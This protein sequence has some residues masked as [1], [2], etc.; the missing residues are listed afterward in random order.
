MSGLTLKDPARNDPVPHL[1]PSGPPAPHMSYQPAPQMW[2]PP[3]DAPSW[4]FGPMGVDHHSA[5]S[6][7][8]TTTATTFGGPAGGSGGAGGGIY[9]PAAPPPSA[10]YMQMPYNDGFQ[11]ASS[12]K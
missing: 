1:V 2:A 9:N 12:G 5:G 7:N 3:S 4:T 8:T 6:N 10:N 11:H